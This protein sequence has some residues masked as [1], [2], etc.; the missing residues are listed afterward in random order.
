MVSFVAPRSS[1]IISFLIASVH[2]NLIKK[3]FL[4]LFVGDSL[5]DFVEESRLQRIKRI[6]LPDCLTGSAA[7]M[8]LPEN[9]APLHDEM[10]ASS[11]PAQNHKYSSNDNSAQKNIDPCTFMCTAMPQNVENAEKHTPIQPM[12]SQPMVSSEPDTRCIHIDKVIRPFAKQNGHQN[13]RQAVL[14]NFDS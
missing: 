3:D 13:C 2:W 10:C 4:F 12:V 7:S 5:A 11:K 6:N 1:F 9:S 8:E 14:L